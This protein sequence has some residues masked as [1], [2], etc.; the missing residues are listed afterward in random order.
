MNELLEKV[1]RLIKSNKTRKQISRELGI[2]IWKARQL[3][4]QA[5]VIINGSPSIKLE[6]ND[7]VFRSEVLRRLKN[8]ITIDKIAEELKTDKKNVENII[9]DLEARGFIIYKKGSNIS[10]GKSIDNVENK[11]IFENHFH[12]K[13]I[14]F[15]VVADMHMASKCERLDVLNLAYDEFARRK[16]NTVLCPG[17]YVDGEARFN[18]HEL[19]AHGIADQCQYAIDNWPQRKGINTYYVDGDDHEG[20]WT[21]REGIE[22]G[23]YLML[24]AKAQGRDDLIY[25]GYMEADIELKA[26]K[27]SC[28]IKVMHAGGGSSYAVSYTSQKL[29]ECVPLNSEILTKTGW[30]KYNELIIGEEVLGFNTQKGINEWCKLKDINIYKNQTVNLYKNDNF[31]VKCT[32]N[33][34]WA[35]EWDKRGSQYKAEIYHYP[36]ETHLWT[37]GECKDRSRII[38]SAKSP[39]GPGLKLLHQDFIDRENAVRII[40]QMTS[41][42]RLAFIYGFTTAEGCSAERNNEDHSKTIVVSQNPG[43]LHDAFILACNLEGYSV[44]VKS[45]EKQCSDGIHICDKMTILS[46][47]KRMV[48]SLKLIDSNEEDVWCPTTELGT[49]IMRQGNVITITGNSFQGGEK[50]A[51]CIV[52]HYHK[53]DYCVDLDSEILTRTGW[54]THTEILSGDEVMG[55]NLDTGFLEWTKLLAINLTPPTTINY[56]SNTKFSINCTADHKWV[57]EQD[58]RRF[59]ASLSQV[60]PKWNGSHPML[61]QAAIGPDGCG[62]GRLGYSDLLSRDTSVE[63][64][65][66]MTSVERQAFIL[67]L[68]AGEGS[69]PKTTTTI[70]FNQ[71]KGP[72]NDAFTLACFLEGWAMGKPHPASG[73]SID[74]LRTGIFQTPYRD[75]RIRESLTK[76]VEAR[77]WCPTTQLGTWVMRQKGQISI[78]GNCYPRSIHIIQPGCCQ[79]Q[80]R[81]M[82]KKKLE[83]HVGFSIISITQDIKGSITKFVPEF[84]PFFDKGYY[85]NRDGIGDRLKNNA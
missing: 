25:M 45:V 21:Q 12:E 20:W 69:R 50:P 23:R 39:G 81:F 63:T 42:E 67:G 65:L 35:I 68:L 73:N 58:G 55:Y 83:A 85:L 44:S 47:N 77:A 43:P 71:N 24:E 60:Q 10:L 27:G 19:K 14:E 2:S 26:P 13:P 48:N 6:P 41:E 61:I 37:I 53:F 74:C 4:G 66:R 3:I 46:K 8:P 76:S 64:V 18:T 22:F 30:K 80:S 70:S 72:V 9:A 7:P 36:E 33:H 17:N 56:Y 57:W 29:A 52:G 75:Y 62:I 40:L 16:I 49:W 31:V 78:T 38:Q 5:K 84:F 59:L 15:G 54:K 32:P 34:K 28:V 79:D 11:I 51:V 82:R 1:I